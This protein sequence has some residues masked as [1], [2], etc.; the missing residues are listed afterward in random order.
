MAN[1]L[2]FY[3]KIQF[4]RTKRTI[5]QA[6]IPPLF[7]IPGLVI[8]I[9]AAYYL[10]IQ[11]PFWGA[12]IISLFSIQVLFNLSAYERNNFLKTIYNTKDYYILRAVENLTISATSIIL[13]IITTHYWFALLIA[14]LCMLFLFTTTFKYWKTKIPTPFTRKPFEFIQGF[15]RTWFLIFTLYLLGGIGILYGNQNL[16]LFCIVCLSICCSFYYQEPENIYLFWN[17]NRKPLSF[18]LYKIKRGIVQLS[19]VLSPLILLFLIFSPFDYFK[20]LLVWLLVSIFIPAIIC[21]KYAVYPRKINLTEGILLS[22]CI[23]FYPLILALIP[24]YISKAIKNL[25]D[26]LS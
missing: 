8:L 7:V 6:G 17:N 25:K 18:L 9:F 23:S 21:L 22:L 26:H 1:M 20:V 2:N 14:L 19:L 15:R 13:L 16:G 11:Y 3:L 24:Y 10:L 5:A 12:C 4:L